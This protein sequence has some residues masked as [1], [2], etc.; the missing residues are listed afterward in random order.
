MKCAELVRH[1]I[2]YEIIPI[3]LLR[4]EIDFVNLL[5]N[6]DEVSTTSTCKKTDFSHSLVKLV[7]WGNIPLENEFEKD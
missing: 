6:L 5:K 3:L 1:L 4:F 7:S 2:N